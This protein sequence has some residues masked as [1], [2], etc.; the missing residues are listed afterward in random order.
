MAEHLFEIHRPVK[1][2]DECG[3]RLI[4]RLSAFVPDDRDM[5]SLARLHVMATELGR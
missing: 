2:A 5:N 3:E 4:R 1:A